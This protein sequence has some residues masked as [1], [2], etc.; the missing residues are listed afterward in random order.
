MPLED[1]VEEIG[2]LAVYVLDANDP[3]AA[4]H[5]DPREPQYSGGYQRYVNT[6]LYRVRLVYY[7]QDRGLVR[8][9]RVQETVG[10]MLDRSRGLYPFV[11]SEFFRTGTLQ[12]WRKFDDLSVAFGVAGISLSRGLTDLANFAA[13][14]W[15]GGGGL[16]PTPVPT[17]K[18]HVGPTVTVRLGGGFEDQRRR[19]E[20]A[21]PA[22]PPKD[23]KLPPR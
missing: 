9:A 12:D 4:A 17:P 8:D 11:G 18:G 21:A 19:S 14:I 3:L 7:G 6:I 22:L 5:S 1:L 23:I 20:S 10:G 16:V 13:F 15:R 2:V